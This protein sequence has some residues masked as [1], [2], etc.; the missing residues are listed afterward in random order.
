MRAG[1]S[2]VDEHEPNARQSRCT[3][4]SCLQRFSFT[5]ELQLS[6]IPDHETDM[7][8]LRRCYLVDRDDVSLLRDRRRQL[9]LRRSSTFCRFLTLPHR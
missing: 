4:Y 1:G 8:A 5:V 9:C 6:C 3:L 2:E 7:Y